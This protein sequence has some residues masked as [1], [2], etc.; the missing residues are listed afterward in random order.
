VCLGRREQLVF[1]VCCYVDRTGAAHYFEGVAEGYI[2]TEPAGKADS[3]M[4]LFS[5]IPASKKPCAASST[6]QESD[7]H[8]SQAFLKF[9][10]YYLSTIESMRTT[11]RGGEDKHE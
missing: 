7:N 4:I 5:T 1:G 8:R 3:A 9:K 11:R 2:A 10:E 6:G